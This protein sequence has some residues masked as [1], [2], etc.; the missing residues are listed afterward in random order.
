MRAQA[1]FLGLGLGFALGSG[2]FLGLGLALDAGFFLGPEPAFGFGFGFGFGSGFSLA[3]N[4]S[5]FRS[6][7]FGFS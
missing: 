2:F 3:F 1:F 4:L 6:S 5:G 7:R